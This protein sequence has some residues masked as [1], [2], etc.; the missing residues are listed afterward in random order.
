MAMKKNHQTEV[1]N[2]DDEKRKI[3]KSY[4]GKFKIKRLK[5]KVT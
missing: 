5:K 3:Q 2:N 1:H 4:L